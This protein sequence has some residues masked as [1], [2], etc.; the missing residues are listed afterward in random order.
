MWG[1]AGTFT[2]ITGSGIKSV[3]GITTSG[4]WLTFPCPPRDAKGSGYGGGGMPEG[5][6]VSRNL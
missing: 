6:A 3:S 1:E 2:K 5:K 4:C